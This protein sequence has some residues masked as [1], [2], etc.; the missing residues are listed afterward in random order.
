MAGSR[1]KSGSGAAVGV[2]RAVGY[3][4]R[5]DAPKTL[6]P[7][8]ALESSLVSAMQGALSLREFL[9]VLLHS[10]VVFPSTTEVMPDGSGMSPLIF[11]K[12]GEQMLAVFTSFE[13]AQRFSDSVKFCLEMDG[14]QFVCRLPA[15]YGVVLNP[16]WTAG[17]EIPPS[18]VVD[19]ARDFRAGFI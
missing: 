13:R 4:G 2:A 18:G 3:D 10:R 8:N 16:G 9:R 19:L 5:M 14:H 7:S 12:E 11:D 15:G 6:V 17:C 1:V